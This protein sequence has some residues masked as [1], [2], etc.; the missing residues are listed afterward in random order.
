MNKELRQLRIKFVAIIMAVAAVILVSVFTA[1]VVLDHNNSVQEVH[2]ALE[3]SINHAASESTAPNFDMNPFEGEARPEQRRDP[4]EIG[5]HETE[6]SLI[7]VAVYEIPKDGGLIASNAASGTIAASA[8]EEVANQAQAL[9]NG[10][11]VLDDLGVYYLKETQKDR[12]FIAFADMQSASGWKSLALLLTGIGAAAL[13]L[14][15][16]VGFLLSKWVVR[17]IEKSWQQQ[18]RF[19]ADASHELKTPLTVIAA[20]V[21]ILKRHPERTI[22]HQSQWVESI[23]AESAQ[24]QGLVEDMLVLASTDAQNG[25]AASQ[26]ERIDLS[27]LVRAHVLQFEPLAY[28]RSISLS[29]TIEEGIFVDGTSGGIQRLISVLVDNAFKYVNE[30]GAISIELANQDGFAVFSVSNTGVPIPPEDLPHLFDRFYRSDKART[31]TENQSFGLGLSIAQEIVHRLK[32][33][34]QASSSEE[35]TTFTVKL[36]LSVFPG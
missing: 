16:L 18:Q 30:H 1:I 22:A 11:G 28:E 33:T 13:A 34:I 29:D 21:A 9:S 24:M 31:R 3:E 25:A 7:P 27:K 4:L 26:L 8:L 17:P 10:Y 20:D 5:G 14:F 2:R 35:N 6:R 19:V 23:E 15:F 12:S 32:G 36:P